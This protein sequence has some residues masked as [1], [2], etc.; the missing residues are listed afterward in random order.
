MAYQRTFEFPAGR[1]AFKTSL[2]PVVRGS[3]GHASTSSA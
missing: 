2:V 1:L 3:R